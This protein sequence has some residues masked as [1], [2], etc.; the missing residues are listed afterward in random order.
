[1][2]KCASAVQHM[3]ESRFQFWSRE[4]SYRYGSLDTESRSMAGLFRPGGVPMRSVAL[5]SIGLSAIACAQVD[6][7]VDMTRKSIEIQPEA[8]RAALPTFGKVE[9][10]HMVF[11]P[12]DIENRN[13]SG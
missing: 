4:R 2:R 5:V 3:N 8:L 6:D 13:T 12:D 1:M 9:G 7:A 10:L 11:L